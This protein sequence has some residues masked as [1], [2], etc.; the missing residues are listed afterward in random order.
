MT[1]GAYLAIPARVNMKQEERA[2]MVN[3][4][5]KLFFFDNWRSSM[6]LMMIFVVSMLMV[7]F[8]PFLV[9]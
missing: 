7:Y 1:M 9:L 2:K 8:E 6:A 4:P 5:F 3:V